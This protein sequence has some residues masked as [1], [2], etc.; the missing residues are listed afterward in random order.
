MKDK[1]HLYPLG[2]KQMNLIRQGKSTT[3]RVGKMKITIGPKGPYM[4]RIALAEKR[5]KILNE[6]K[7][8]GRYR[9]FKAR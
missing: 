5:K 8:L 2:K 4:E 7:S 3:L 1:I 6:M 9:V